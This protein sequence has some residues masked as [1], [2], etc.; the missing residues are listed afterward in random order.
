MSN[1]RKA[2]NEAYS[3]LFSTRDGRKFLELV[4]HYFDCA[5]IDRP[6]T[7]WMVWRDLGELWCGTGVDEVDICHVQAALHHLWMVG[8]VWQ[9]V[10]PIGP[11][12]KPVEVWFSTRIQATGF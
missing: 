12:N 10:E 2:I 4:H 3:E 9:T 7:L 1:H 5:T 6:H 11:Q 8:E